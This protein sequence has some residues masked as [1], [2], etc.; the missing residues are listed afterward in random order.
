MHPKRKGLNYVIHSFVTWV[1]LIERERG[2]KREKEK[3]RSNGWKWL[4]ECEISQYEICLKYTQCLCTSIF[5]SIRTKGS[6]TYIST[7]NRQQIWFPYVLSSI[8][9]IV[10]QWRTSHCMFAICVCYL[11]WKWLMNK[12]VKW[13]SSAAHRL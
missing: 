5:E 10:L 11:S 8:Q 12:K 7:T 13:L 2:N 6:A 3:N 9:Y 1:G 4:D